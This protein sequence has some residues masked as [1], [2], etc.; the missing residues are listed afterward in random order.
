MTTH[1]DAIRARRRLTNRLIA[2][3]EAERLRPF[4]LP[5]VKLIV[6]DGGLILGADSVIEA[7]AAQFADPEFRTY[8]RET[9]TVSLD[10]EGLRAAEAGAWTGVYRDGE[11]R[12]TYLA[13][14]RNVRGQWA[15]ESELYVTLG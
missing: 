6:G 11:L 13:V 7:F 4:F 1:D 10:A 14:W 8:V 15:I 2:A 5:D 9:E 3:H 12:G